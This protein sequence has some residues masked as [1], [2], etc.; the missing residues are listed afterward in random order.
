MADCNSSSPPLPIPL[1]T[2]RAQRYTNDSNLVTRPET[3]SLDVRTRR[4]NGNVGIDTR[5]SPGNLIRLR[6]WRRGGEGQK[7]LCMLRLNF[8]FTYAA[9]FVSPKSQICFD[10]ADFSLDIFWG[11]RKTKYYAVFDFHLVHLHRIFFFS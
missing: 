9:Y 6:S 4:L 5:I 7:I 2:S 11:R 8:I 10:L 3:A 1:L